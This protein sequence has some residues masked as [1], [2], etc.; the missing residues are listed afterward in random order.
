MAAHLCPSTA[1]GWKGP[2]KLCRATSALAGCAYSA[3][4]QAASALY[5]KAVLQ[6]FQVK[7]L[8]NE[9]AGL[10]SSSRRGLRSATDLASTT[11]ATAQATSD[12]IRMT[13]E[14]LGPNSRQAGL[15][16]RAC[17]SPTRL[18]DASANLC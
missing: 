4:G 14:S 16:E 17:R 9:E 11:K 10:D 1:I 7:V 15:T 18:T 2:S 5:S 13:L 8:A 3:A 6:V 12:S